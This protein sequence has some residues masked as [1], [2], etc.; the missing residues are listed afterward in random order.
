MN[1]I[2]TGY[3]Y[4]QNLG[5]DLF[6]A[7]SRKI[8]LSNKFSK[9]FPII[10]YVRIEDLYTS[11]YIKDCSRIILFGGETLNDYFL[12]RLLNVWLKNK[13]IKFNAIGVSTN[14]DYDTIVNKINLFDTVLFRNKLDYEYF[15]NRINCF[16][17]PDI[18]FLLN[19]NGIT[20]FIHTVSII[21]QKQVG[22]FLSQT[23]LLNLS[24]EQQK[25][26]LKNISNVIKFWI[27]NDYIVN[28]FPMCTNNKIQEDDNIINKKVYNLLTESEKR[29]IR[30]HTTNIEIVNKIKSMSFN[31]CV[32]DIFCFWTNTDVSKY[33]SDSYYYG[34]YIG[35]SN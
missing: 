19:N 26:Y 3:Y 22:F 7:I 30:S 16:Y 23:V 24:S 33:P 9:I 1:V 32:I 5:D 35:S 34:I 15:K 13:S 12:D 8:F 25:S 21:K 4:H 17:G 28:L 2:I 10:K 20:K 11:E 6:E 14:Q 31:F 27:N 29:K 18:V